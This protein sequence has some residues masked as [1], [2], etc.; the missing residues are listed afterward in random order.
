MKLKL[1][2]IIL[3]VWA[4]IASTAFAITNIAATST[5]GVQ[6]NDLV[7]YH[8]SNDPVRGSGHHVS[9]HE[10]V[11]YLFANKENKQTFDQNPQ[12]YL[13]AYGGYCAYGVSVGK[14]FIGDPEVWKVVDGTLY[15]NLDN[16]IQKEWLKNVPGRI[17]A[18]NKKWEEIKDKSPKEL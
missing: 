17:E 2:P 13:P 5:T 16:K 1:I 10:G 3:V 14:K 15:L 9:E 4:G 18:A 6:G 8:T 11:T 12:K 7:S